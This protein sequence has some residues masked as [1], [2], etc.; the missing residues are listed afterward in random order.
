MV[1]VCIAN[2]LAALVLVPTL[3]E[4]YYGDITRGILGE[5]MTLALS[6]RIWTCVIFF[7]M[8]DSCIDNYKE[9]FPRLLTFLEVEV[10]VFFVLC[11]IVLVG[12][13][14]YCCIG[15]S[16]AENQV[17]PTSDQKVQ[18]DLELG[19]ITTKK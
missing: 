18:E 19:Q 13:F 17:T 12:M 11:A 10:Y 2:F 5:C 9:K 1:L 14:T 6:V 15:L 4:I 7:G 8:P 16:N 3:V